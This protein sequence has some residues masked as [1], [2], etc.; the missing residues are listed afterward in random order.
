MVVNTHWHSD[1]TGA[2]R[3][4]VRLSATLEA[5]PVL[6][7]RAARRGN[8]G[9]HGPRRCRP[10]AVVRLVGRGRTNDQQRR[11]GCPLRSAPGPLRRSG[12]S[13]SDATDGS[14]RR[15]TLLQRHRRSSSSTSSKPTNSDAA[16]S[17]PPQMPGT[18]PRSPDSDHARVIPPPRQ[19]PWPA[20]AATGWQSRPAFRADGPASTRADCRLLLEWHGRRNGSRSI[21][22]R[23]P[24]TSA[25]FRPPEGRRLWPAQGTFGSAAAA[26][27][28]AR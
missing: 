19:R 18:R 3:R 11:G 6:R 24:G 23:R 2:R 25:A 4:H 10:R 7:D 14:S 8:P 1:H 16:S 17:D 15:A 20:D 27:I 12:F 21:T 9:D 5:R 22:Y 13:R 26:A 28:Q